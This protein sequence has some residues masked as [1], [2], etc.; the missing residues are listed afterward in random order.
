MASL[1]VG[2]L[3]TGLLSPT[4]EPQGQP[5]GYVK[6]V[7]GAAVI[8]RGGAELAARPGDAIYPSDVL[9]TGV[10]GHL[11]VTLKDDTRVSLGANSEI[12]LS[13]FEFRPAEGQL[14]LVMKLLRGVA[15]FVT[16]RIA[17]LNP[18]G[19]RIETPA[20]IVGVRG[21][22]VAVRAGAPGEPRRPARPGRSGRPGRP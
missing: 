2:V 10:G 6:I 16:G 11:G 20:S 15:A 5:A 21:T 13:E 3:L 17:R 7:T 22:H 1:V 8:M 14:A 12:G 18:D 19:M 4:L 9:R